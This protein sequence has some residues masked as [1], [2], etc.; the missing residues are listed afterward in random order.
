MEPRVAVPWYAT[1]GKEPERVI[2]ANWEE[3]RRLLAEFTP[4]LG[5]SL[6]KALYL[7]ERILDTDTRWEQILTP[8]KTETNWLKLVYPIVYQQEVS[9]VR[10]AIAA[11]YQKRNTGEGDSGGNILTTSETE[12][13]EKEVRVER[14][15]VGKILDTE[16]DLE[17]IMVE[18]CTLH[19]EITDYALDDKKKINREWCRFFLP[20]MNRLKALLDRELVRN[21]ELK[22]VIKGLVY[23][24]EESEG[25]RSAKSK[26]K[27]FAEIVREQRKEE[28]V[29]K[30]VLVRE[31]KV[32]PK[33]TVILYPKDIE[34]KS[35]VTKEALKS[36]DP[37]KEQ[38]RVRNVRPVG[39]GGV[40]IEA[41]DE[42]TLLKLRNHAKLKEMGI[43]VETPRLR[44][45]KVI[46][47]DVPREH[48]SE[49]FI[50]KLHGQNF[51]GT[52]VTVDELKAEVTVRARTGPRANQEKVNLILEVSPRMR[53][54][55]VD[56]ERFYIGFQCCR[57]RDYVVPM[58]CYKCLQFGHSKRLCKGSMTCAHCAEAGH[59]F[60]ECQHKTSAVKCA[61]C[62]REKRKETN[63]RVDSSDC[64]MYQKAL[65]KEIDRID[66]G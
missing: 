19:E 35:E 52:E 26:P 60:S 45:P 34:Q 59:K 43:R 36:L 56:K 62:V 32:I 47:F 13:R 38:L 2:S 3:R 7:I 55:L 10:A 54:L 48:D 27:P 5:V 17:S 66:Y 44:G 42:S 57:A 1:F 61:N 37:V 15:E 21:A 31:R 40:L 51:T 46:L 6:E 23:E 8:T 28:G 25:Q 18:A 41:A 20:K 16:D 50:E 33:K 22:G 14:N 29:D 9:E 49:G 11:C 53:R 64:P 39:K 30:T 4:K 24:G 58:R 12:E 65:A 63:H